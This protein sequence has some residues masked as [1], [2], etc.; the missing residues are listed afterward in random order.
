MS[1][2]RRRLREKLKEPSEVIPSPEYIRRHP[3]EAEA[4]LKRARKEEQLIKGKYE[5][6]LKEYER[7]LEK[8]LK[9]IESL[10]DKL[11]KDELTDAIKYRELAKEYSKY[12]TVERIFR[13]IATVKDEHAKKL[14]AV[15]AELERLIKEKRYIL[16]RK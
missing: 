13:T 4:I 16:G 8:D 10:F 15:F 5:R 14:H 1:E 2:S 9:R 12:P 3:E 11:A 6:A 7:E